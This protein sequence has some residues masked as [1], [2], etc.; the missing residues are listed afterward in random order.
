MNILKA[1]ILPLIAASL[2]SGLSQLEAKQSGWI[3]LFA[4]IY[5]SVTMILA[6]VVNK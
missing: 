4:L 5:Y 3:G 1:M 2:V 6:V